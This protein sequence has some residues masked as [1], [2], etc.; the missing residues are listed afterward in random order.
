M[1]M[2]ECK[3]LAGLVLGC[4]CMLNAIGQ[5]ILHAAA[6]FVEFFLGMLE[7]LFKCSS[8]CSKHIGE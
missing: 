7:V 4:A 3:V 6:S 1:A 5:R 2:V 8:K